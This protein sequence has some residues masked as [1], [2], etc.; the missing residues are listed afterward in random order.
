MSAAIINMNVPSSPLPTLEQLATAVSPSLASK[1]PGSEKIL[2]KLV[3]EAS[4]A[5]MPK[6]P[7][8][9]NVDSVRVV[10]VLGGGLDASRVVRGMVFG[11]EPEGRSPDPQRGRQLTCRRYRE[12][13]H[14]SQGRRLHLWLGHL[15]DGD[16]GHGAVEKGRGVA[17]LHQRR[18]EAA[19]R[20]KLSLGLAR[21]WLI[22]LRSTS[23]RSPILVSSSSL[24]ALVLEIWP[25]T[26]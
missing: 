21:T 4:L 7:K 23:K 13:R 14:E 26:T 20:R 18:G 15:A 24:L 8:D 5:I 1:Q 3:A 16:Q 19:R 6:N 11:R 10:K 2:A 25:C 22:A 9:F 12:E 17:R